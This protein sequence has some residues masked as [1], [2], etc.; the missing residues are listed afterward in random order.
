MSADKMSVKAEKTNPAAKPVAAKP[1]AAPAPAVSAVLPALFRK[2]DWLAMAIAFAVVWVIYFNTLAPEL[3]LED[4]GEL[5][6]GSFYAGIPHPPGYPFWAIYSWLW[7][8][9]LPI[10]NIAWRVEVGEATAEAIGCGMVALIVSRG[11]SMLM[12]GIGELKELTG[13]WENGICLVSGAVAGILLGLGGTMWMESVAINRISLFGVPWV[14]AV[15]LC[16]LRWIYAPKQLRYLFCA[17]L[18]FGICATIHQTLLVAAMGIEAAVAFARP[19]LGR[20]FFLGNSIIFLGGCIAHLSHVTAALDVD[21]TLLLIFFA[22]GIGS[23]A[24]YGFFAI[25]TKETFSE[26]CLDGGAAGFLLFAVL[27]VAYGFIFVLLSLVCLAIFIYQLWNTRK[28]GLEWLIA[29]ACLILFC[30]G[31]AFYFYEPISGMT[32]PPMEWGYPR[33]VDGFFHALS[34]GQYEKAHPTDIIHEPYKFMLQLVWLAKHNVEDYNWILL[35]VALIPFLFFFKMQ[36]RERSWLTCL[37]VTYL[38]IGP[39]LVILMN[40][41]ED[42]SSTDLHK[43][44][45][46]SSHGIVAILFG[47]GLALTAGYMATH[48]QRFRQWGLMGAGLALTLALYSLY[49]AIRVHY[50]GIGGS[51]PNNFDIPHYITKAFG[52][53]QG[54]QPIF[55]SLILLA[56]P[57]AF[58]AGLLI[59]K[60]RAPLA[61]TLGLFAVL[62]ISSGLS[63]WGS[64]E[65]RDHW[66]GYWFGHDMFTPPYGIYP[67]MTKDAVLF[68]GTDPGRFCP[69]YMIF[70][71]SFTPHDQQPKATK[72]NYESGDQKF[73]R[74][75]VYIITQNAL[76]DPTYLEYI[77]AQYNRSTQI[78]PPFFQELLRGKKEVDQNYTT[79]FVARLAYQLL[80]VPLTRFGANV[81]ARRRKEGVYPLKEIYIPNSEDSSRCYSE[82][83]ADASQRYEHD[84]RFPNEPKQLKPMEEVHQAQGDRVSVS[85]QVAVMSINGL[86]TKVIFDHNPTNEFFVEE[87]FPL[88]WMYPYES[89]YGI[90]MKI[91]RQPLDELTPKML[92]DDHA[93]WS[94]YSERLVGKWL[95]YDTSLTDIT[96]FV[97][98][99]NMK[100]DYNGFTGDRKFIRDEEAQKAFSKLRSSIAGLYE[101]RF[102]HARNATDQQRMLKEADFAYRQAFAYCPYSPEAVFHY[103]N[104]LLTTGR[105][106]DAVS[107]GETCFRL[108]PNNEQVE[109]MVKNLHDIKNQHLNLAPSQVSGNTQQLEKEVKDNPTDFQK[110]FNLAGAYIQLQQP[111]KAMKVLDDVL[112]NPKVEPNAVIFLAKAYAQMGNY[113][114][115]EI[116][117]EKLTQLQPHSPE[118]WCDLAAMKIAVGKAS[119]AYKDLKVS[120]DE[121]AKRLAQNPKA[122]N[123]LLTIRAD[124]RFAGISNTPEFQQV[125]GLK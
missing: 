2:V 117:L 43:V 119:E 20:T 29:I 23:I 16:M 35:F 38:C 45:F 46:A 17:M 30:S 69:T 51:I 9:L 108:D 34:R 106:D 123:L 61:L 115:L 88:D 63:H 27:G 87:S 5:C 76:A 48:Y 89:P 107:V 54:G 47:Y 58:L 98:K 72:A 59:Y 118:A 68:G 56:L 39:L 50:F 110:A 21:N 37:A 104:L 100:H 101:W 28:L 77:R 97:D 102:R 40:P 14:M 60:D 33:T 70:C 93:F 55:G 96:N 19:R 71:E 80:D 26:F 91:N 116:A 18:F 7:T 92:E 65:Q 67:E 22:V 36:R 125:V 82:Y 49:D 53:N 111:D 52:A 121:N 10:G 78:D 81:E 124:P 105:V 1:P 112:A 75:D 57:F 84:Q 113:P 24:A 15:L 32:N 6:T 95:T 109:N 12:E 120:V 79:N 64:S 41:G 85:G 122:S 114:K 94:K 25:I 74:R 62:P 31:A 66:F 3:T 103:V 4:S 83:M 86:L 44:F 73:D 90:I 13:K 99:V 8:V 11:S 42:K